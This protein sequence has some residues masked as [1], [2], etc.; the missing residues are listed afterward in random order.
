MNE[1]FDWLIAVK[2][3]LASSILG[4]AKTETNL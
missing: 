2:I 3:G 4:K 1:H